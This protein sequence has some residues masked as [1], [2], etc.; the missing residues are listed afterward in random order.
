M[1]S[2]P[3]LT[4]RLAVYVVL[5]ADTLAP[6]RDLPARDLPGLA[7]AAVAGGAGTLQV[8]AKHASGRAMYD[9][10]ERVAAEVLD[11]CASV[12]LLVND[13]VDV[14]AAA[15]HA[16]LPVA[17][18]HIGQSDLPPVAARAVLG[19]QAVL[20]LSA[21][22]VGEVRAVEALPAGTVSYLGVSPV[23]ATTTKPDARAPL[24]VEGAAG[25]AAA[26]ALPC[27]GIGGL[28]VADA[29]WLRRAGFAGLAVVS[30]VSLAPDPQAA[31]RALV[32]AWRGVM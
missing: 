19:P 8:R 28:S 3:N 16:G 5:D 2:W 9:L 32:D 14:A 7:R 22:T 21:G 4:D 27:V 12:V 11:C 1:T 15:R 24:G 17:G 13:R 26:T 10:V 29:G 31:T 25:L 18:A 30:A 23:H 6:G 20:G